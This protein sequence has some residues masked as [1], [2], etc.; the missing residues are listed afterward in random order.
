MIVA[1]DKNQVYL[2]QGELYFS[3]ETNIVNTILGSCLCAIFYNSRT[4]YAGM[5]HAMLPE[6]KMGTGNNP[7]LYVDYA[8]R[9]L[10]N[11][12]FNAGIPV[13]E[14]TV[15]LFGGGSV[16]RFS[17]RKMNIGIRNIETAFKTLLEMGLTV[18]VENT[19]GEF[20][21]KLFFYTGTGRVYL[22]RI[23]TLGNI[24]A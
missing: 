14:I 21:R 7:L 6:Y 22:K 15:K 19:G 10:G 17:G 3:D 2:S 23:N 13:H 8:L 1:L 11:R 9:E 18:S 16:L 12:F 4:K 5:I 24:Y 20:G